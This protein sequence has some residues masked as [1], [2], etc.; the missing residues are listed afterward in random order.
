MDLHGLCSHRTAPRQYSLWARNIIIQCKLAQILSLQSAPF[1]ILAR[2]ANYYVNFNSIQQEFI[3]E[4]AEKIT[5][6]IMITIKHKQSHNKK[7]LNCSQRKLSKRL[8]N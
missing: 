6:N 2:C 3:S 8:K 7:A 5:E 4:G 1:V